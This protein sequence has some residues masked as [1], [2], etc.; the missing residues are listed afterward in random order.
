[1]HTQNVMLRGKSRIKICT[2]NIII[3]LKEINIIYLKNKRKI[4]NILIFVISGG[5]ISVDYCEEIPRGDFQETRT[6]RLR[7]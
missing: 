7:D 2:Y 5:G 3:T 6:Q 4:S 1:M